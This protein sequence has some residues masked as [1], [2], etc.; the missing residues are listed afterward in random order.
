MHCSFKPSTWSSYIWVFPKKWIN[1]WATNPQC[2]AIK[3]VNNEYDAGE[4]IFQKNICIEK[5]DT[6]TTLEEKIHKLEY[7]YY[8]KVIQSL[9]I[10]WIS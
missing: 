5:N 6:V 8:P 4:I 1:S 2:L 9:L 10:K 3:W 7:E